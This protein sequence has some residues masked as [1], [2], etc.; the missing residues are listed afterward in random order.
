MINTQQYKNKK[1]SVVGFA[2]S[3]LA[4]ANLL[5]RLGAEVSVTDSK[6]DA[7]TRLN[8]S[9]L[10]SRDISFELGKHTP[11]IVKGRDLVVVSPGI[12]DEAMPLVWAKE[13]G[14]P[15]I[16]EIEFA[17]SLCPA[18]VIAVT[19]SNGKT[20]VTTL[21]GEV[22]KKKGE[23]VFVCGNIGNPFSGE[24]DKM[25][26]SDFVSL[27]ISSFQLEKITTFRPAIAVLLNFSRNHLDRYKDMD[28]Y[29][30]AKKRI[31]L[32][33]GVSD[34][35]VLNRR[36]PVSVA[37]ERE[38]RSRIVYFNENDDFNPNHCAVMAVGSLLGIE[39]AL[40]Q[41]VFAEFKGVEHRMEVVAEINKVR[42][43]NDSKATTV[44]S[45][46]WAL[47]SI[48]GPVILIAGGKDK[49]NDYR[50]ILDL[51]RQK[52][53]HAILI[54][55][56]QEKMKLVFQGQLPVYAAASLPDAV[57]LAYTLAKAGDSVLL[58]PMCASFDM[59]TDY[60]HR[61]R[62]FKQAVAELARR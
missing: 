53:K 3:G 39:K 11:A 34:Y 41:E 42:F 26:E 23:K 13:F 44:D 21:I 1:V 14:I 49:G 33:Q 16:S 31:F 46:M 62:V 38:A 61:G 28:A 15:V 57:R 9:R 59:F 27:E 35:L 8:V 50:S 52:V 5:Y 10:L 40:M 19:G 4:C 43:I 12:P 2:R 56:A 25:Q 32:N 36:D 24:V 20:T 6:D 17:W 29:L 7:Q 54:G 60:E 58:S 30:Q 18:R 22:L 48:P 37:I 55:Q 47:R 51:A 45:A